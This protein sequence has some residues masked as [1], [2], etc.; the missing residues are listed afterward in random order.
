MQTLYASEDASSPQPQIRSSLAGHALY[1]DIDGTILDLAPNPEDVEV[2]VWMV[3][4]LQRLWLKLDGAVAFVSGRSVAAIDTL[5]RPLRLPTI[6]VHGGEIRVSGDR[7]IVDESLAAELQAMLPLLH[8]ATAYLPGVRLENKRCA[9]ALHYR[10]VPERGHEVLKL[11]EMV[12]ARLGAAFAVLVGKCVVE[13]RPR[14]LTKGAGIRRLME[15]EPFRG[16]SPIFAGDDVTDEDAFQVVN[17]MGGISVRV[18]EAAPTAATYR[19]SDPDEL[20]R[21][22]LEIAQP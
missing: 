22:L 7:I 13:I 3:P 8:D 5:F 9:I 15:R 19:L 18:G 2:P 4:L 20:R 11:A 17:H 14:H 6:G 16:R 10:S 21:W 1:L 12:V